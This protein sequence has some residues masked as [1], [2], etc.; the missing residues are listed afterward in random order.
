MGPTLYD[1]KPNVM[2]FLNEHLVFRYDLT[3]KQFSM[4]DLWDSLHYLFPAF[5][6]LLNGSVF[7]SGGISKANNTEPVANSFMM[8]SNGGDVI[9]AE[10]MIIPRY[11]HKM[12]FCNWAVYSLGGYSKNRA[13]TSKVERYNFASGE[14]EGMPK[15]YHEWQSFYVCAAFSSRSIYVVGGC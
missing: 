6:D 9:Q 5:C 7:F 15:M 12:V 11:K 2:H 1:H 14:W 4:F 13:M 8:E 3:W 10:N